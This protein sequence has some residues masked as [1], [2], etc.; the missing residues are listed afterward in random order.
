MRVHF[1]LLDGHET[2]RDLEGVE[3]A[4]L[5][6]A[7]VQAIRAVQEL[8][9][10]DELA[11]Q[12]WSGWTLSVADDRGAVLFSLAL[13]D[14]ISWSRSRRRLSATPSLVLT[15]CQLVQQTPHMLPGLPSGVVLVISHDHL[16]H[17]PC[18]STASDHCNINDT[19]I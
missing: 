7:R 14:F 15:S 8:A 13:D 5:Q 17:E 4:D 11:A 2:I 18:K 19:N 16:Q 3:V 12:S 6:E 1:H 10:E 9:Q